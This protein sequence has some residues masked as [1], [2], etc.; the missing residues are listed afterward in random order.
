M[1]RLKTNMTQ[2]KRLI[3]VLV[4]VGVFVATLAF[5]LLTKNSFADE[6]VRDVSADS[7]HTSYSS[8]EQ[9]AWQ[10]TKKA[11]FG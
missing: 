9:G 10:L 8:R 1:K 2:H 6:P 5:L 3:G 11:N 4:F 7:V